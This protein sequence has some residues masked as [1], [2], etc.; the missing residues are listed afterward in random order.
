VA[1]ARVAQSI[2]QSFTDRMITIMTQQERTPT[3]YKLPYWELACVASHHILPRPP[4]GAS[5][6]RGAI[7]AA[8]SKPYTGQCPSSITQPPW[9]GIQRWEIVYYSRSTT[10]PY[11][12]ISTRLLTYHTPLLRACT[13]VDPVYPMTINGID[14]IDADY[15]PKPLQLL[16]SECFCYIRIGE[17]VLTNVP[18]IDLVVCKC[19]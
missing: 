2:L 10:T 3:Q 4:D 7:S 6:S 18:F 11:V 12:D 5:C 1:S 8:E 15:T 19:C 13:S 17:A 9:K 16:P 14:G